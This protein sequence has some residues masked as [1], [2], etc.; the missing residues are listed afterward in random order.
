MGLKGFSDNIGKLYKDSKYGRY[1]A[2][3]QIDEVDFEDEIDLQKYEDKNKKY[4]VIDTFLEYGTSYS[5]DIYYQLDVGQNTSTL[6]SNETQYYPYS[7]YINLQFQDQE[8]LTDYVYEDYSLDDDYGDKIPVIMPIDL[9]VNLVIDPEDLYQ[10]KNEQRYNM[11][12]EALND[13]LGK[14]YRLQYLEYSYSDTY[15]YDEYNPDFTPPESDSDPEWENTDI[16]VIVVGFS[17]ESNFNTSNALIFPIWAV[18]NNDLQALLE[19]DNSSYTSIVYELKDKDSR[20]RIAEKTDYEIYPITTVWDGTEEAMKIIRYITYGIGGFM[21][22]ISS[23]IT[24]FTINKVVS[25]SKREIGIFRA[26]GAK[27]SDIRAIFFQYSFIITNIGFVIGYIVALS[28]NA[29]VSLIWGR[30]LFFSVA[31]FATNYD[32]KPPWFMFIGFPVLEFILIYVLSALSGFVATF[33]PAFR[34]SAMDV[35]KAIREE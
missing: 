30:E 2:T 31:I 20:T 26:V 33:I 11:V 32:I 19:N 16:E 1:F 28:F 21:L 24:F 12:Q 6:P 5:S 22:F 14:S 15:Y 17:S 4:G 27:K 3:E 13:Y 9:V 35:V 18:E 34:A 7:Q 23:L 10:M 25:D 29:I 8:F